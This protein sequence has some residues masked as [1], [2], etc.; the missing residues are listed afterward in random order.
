MTKYSALFIKGAILLAIFILSVLFACSPWG[1]HLELLCYDT[2]FIVRGP[3][4]PSRQVVVVA[5]DEASFGVFK[6]RWPWPRRRH[7]ELLETLFREGAR[8]VA[9]DALFAEPSGPEDDQIL[10]R[11]VRS[12]S[13]VVMAAALELVDAPAYFQGTVVY[14]LPSLISDSTHVGIINLPLDS[15]GFVRKAFLSYGAVPSIS[16]AAAKAFLL[17][18]GKNLSHEYESAN[19]EIMVNYAGPPRSISTVSYYQALDPDRYLPKGFFRDKLVFIG[20]SLLT[21]PEVDTPVSDHFF[22]P[23]SRKGVNVI[24]GVEI[25][26]TLAGNLLAGSPI[27]PL[28]RPLIW[29]C[30][31][32]IAGF[33]SLV[34]CRPAFAITATGC[35]TGVA[36]LMI[37][38]LFLSRNVYVP[39]VFFLLPLL[40]GCVVLPF[41]HLL[42]MRK[43]RKYI[44]DTFSKY[45]S[46][47]VVE[48]LLEDPNQVRLGGHMVNASVLY[49]DI[50]GFSR[51]AANMPPDRLVTELSRYLGHFTET[52]LKW[53]GMVDKYVGDAIM[54]IWGAPLPQADHAVRACRAALEMRRNLDA[55]L[56]EDPKRT[57]PEMDIRI[58]INSGDML[59]GNVGGKHFLNYTVHGD[60]TNFAVRL[61]ALNKQY[62]THILIGRETVEQIGD[63]FVVR[64]IDRIRMDGSVS[65]ATL[66]ELI[67]VS[68]DA[69]EEMQRRIR[70]FETAKCQYLDREFE[71]AGDGFSQILSRDDTD[72]PSHVYLERCLRYQQTPPPDEWDGVTDIRIK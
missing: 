36:L 50:A 19:D 15:D 5:I 71:A 23:Y 51:M 33:M 29:A 16:L 1:K 53:D 4:P 25:Q 14:P 21:T 64:E 68:S 57:N 70:M 67:G 10:S 63:E 72:G 44:R 18:K 52:I 49:L 60:A 66:Y 48:K 45:V 58:G 61:E 34:F 43:D 56:L 47:K 32:W 54:A 62:G 40:G 41:P 31:I 12:H 69:D 22:F 8:V 28:S 11:T 59:A 9:I 17:S 6:Q 46:P 37:Y 24:S 20:L 3:K 55:F 2:L 7:A 35:M 26:A 42:K 13:G 27:R 65:N 30:F 38:Y 39:P